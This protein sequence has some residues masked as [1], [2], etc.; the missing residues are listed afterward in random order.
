[1]KFVDKWIGWFTKN[2]GDQDY[3][4][5]KKAEYSVT[6]IHYLFIAVSVSTFLEVNLVGTLYLYLPIT[7]G[8]VLGFGFMLWLI[9]IKQLELSI[10]LLIIA[11]FIR[12]FMIYSYPT[13]FQFYVMCLLN[14]VTI[15]V[16]H[17]KRYQCYI[18]YLGVFLMMA[19]KVPQMHRLSM[20]DVIHW[21]AYT[22]TL[23]ALVL[24][25]IFIL[26]TEFIIE[27]VHN[28]IQKS[29]QL[30]LNANTDHLTGILNR[31]A[32]WHLRDEEISGKSEYSVVLVDID[33]FKL[34]NDTLGHSIG[35]EVL[36]KIA[37][38]LQEQTNTFGELYRWGGEEFLIYFPRMGSEDAYNKAE[39]IR[40]VI[41]QSNLVENMTI[42]ASFGVAE[43][44]GDQSLDVVISKA[45]KAMYQ[46]KQMGR[47]RVS[48]VGY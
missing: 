34:V 22:E 4:L 2:Y 5:T 46:S 35:D 30:V 48:T 37:L 41:E 3:F 28:E 26:M 45:D 18:I 20:T 39:S 6:L 17:V 47:N 33:H 32:F 14:V 40:S 19:Y 7:I 24:F 27:I 16:I 42:T 1:M 29:N 12:F 31:R 44:L 36:I 21:R 11:G 43:Q 23:Y 8:L 25:V 15:A 9:R 10:N 38:L 13:P